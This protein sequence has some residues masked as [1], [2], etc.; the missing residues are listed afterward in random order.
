MRS[1]TFPDSAYNISC[2]Y[3]ETSSRAMA[4]ERH[5]VRVQNGFPARPNPASR[6]DKTPW[7]VDTGGKWRH[8]TIEMPPFEQEMPPNLHRNGGIFNA[9]TRSRRILPTQQT[10]PV[11]RL[12]AFPPRRN[13]RLQTPRFPAP[14]GNA[15]AFPQTYFHL[16]RNGN[17]HF[18]LYLQRHDDFYARKI[19]EPPS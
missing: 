3:Y 4:R 8:Y 12:K 15:S 18:T 7:A 6:V 9:C 14:Y 16:R 11:H 5:A 19:R 13:R 10:R 1:I 2:S 17:R